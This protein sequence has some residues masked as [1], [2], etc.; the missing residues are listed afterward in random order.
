M[1]NIELEQL[2]NRYKLPIY[3]LCMKL[4]LSKDFADDLFSETWVRIT[5]RF[6]QVDSNLNTFNWIYTICLNIYR[7]EKRKQLILSFFSEHDHIENL[8]ISEEFYE[9]DSEEDHILNSAL[10]NLKDKYRI[11]ILLFY[12][13]NLSYEDIS[14]IM[15]IPMSTVKYRLHRAKIILKTKMLKYGR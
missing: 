2:Y 1:N 6:D 12:F 7:K 15:G 8:V 11:P 9:I 10:S 4:T 5:E 3:S 13:K 14:E